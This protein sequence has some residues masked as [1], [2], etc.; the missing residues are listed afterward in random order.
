ML[1]AFLRRERPHVSV[2]ELVDWFRKY[3]YLPRI[4]SDQV[5][6]DALVNPSAALTGETTFFLADG[7]EEGSGRYAGLR[8]HQ[9]SGSQLPSRN[10]LIVKEDVAKAQAEAPIA[11]TADPPTTSSTSAGGFTTSTGFQSTAT[12][13][14]GGSESCCPSSN[15]CSSTQQAIQLYRLTEACPHAG[16]A[17]DG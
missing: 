11:P 9:A 12:G 13:S 1:N 10:T 5:I 4:T 14:S 2:R 17:A 15:R 7:Y 6:L 3:L 16:W 8:P